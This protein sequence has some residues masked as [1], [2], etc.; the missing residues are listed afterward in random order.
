MVLASLLENNFYLNKIFIVFYYIIE[1]S[2]KFL[3]F[4]DTKI[5]HNFINSILYLIGY[6]N[7]IVELKQKKAEEKGDI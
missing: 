7:T 6:L 5:I 3:Y 1:I 2:G 4:I